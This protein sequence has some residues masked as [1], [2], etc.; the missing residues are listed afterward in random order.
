MLVSEF[1]LDVNP[2]DAFLRAKKGV[3]PDS[4]KEYL[5]FLNMRPAGLILSSV[6]TPLKPYPWENHTDSEWLAEFAHN[7]GLFISVFL[8]LN[9]IGSDKSF[10]SL[11]DKA[12]LEY[13]A[14]K[15]RLGWVTKSINKPA[16]L[17]KK[18]LLGVESELKEIDQTFSE[19][20]VYNRAFIQ[21]QF[22]KILDDTGNRSGNA[23]IDLERWKPDWT[24]SR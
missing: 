21:V 10:L 22:T 9:T 14:S 17:L 15:Q 18:L 5:V 12:E 2:I 11:F 1:Y 24:K 6:I 7:S 19:W 20:S 4:I 23:I 8:R 13:Q 3:L 16:K